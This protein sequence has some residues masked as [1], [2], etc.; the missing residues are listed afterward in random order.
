MEVGP[1]R[2][3]LVTLFVLLLLSG[4]AT[5]GEEWNDIWAHDNTYRNWEH[6]KF[7]WFGY[8]NPTVETGRMSHAQG[9]WGKP[10][11]G[12]GE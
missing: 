2:S 6:L 5:T 9:W 4:C 11:P 12:P 10:I 7:S 8:K 1:M 3:F